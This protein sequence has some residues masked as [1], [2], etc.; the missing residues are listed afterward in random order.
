MSRL[1]TSIK[2]T[3]QLFRA[4]KRIG[5][6]IEYQ[7]CLYLIIGIEHFKIYGQQMSIWY[8]VQN[9]EKHD[10]ISKQTEY[11]EHGLEE[12]CVQYKYDDKRFDS[13]QL[14]R[15][16]P[17]KDEQYKV[18]EYTDIVLKGTDIEVSF[19]ARKVIPINRKEAKT[20][21]VAEKKKK[22]AIEIV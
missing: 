15:T 9:L 20:R 21:Y 10:F 17:Y 13:L 5:E 22:L 7:K 18:I 6:T 3:I 11:R 12:M 14:G 4:P 8:T 16:I 1:I 19:L 2:S